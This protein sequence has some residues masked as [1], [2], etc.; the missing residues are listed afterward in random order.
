M[1]TWCWRR[2]DYAESEEQNP[3]ARRSICGDIGI[4]RCSALWVNEATK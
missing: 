3:Y 2:C 1:L 4:I